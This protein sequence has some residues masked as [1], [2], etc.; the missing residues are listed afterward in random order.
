MEKTT[1]TSVPGVYESF[2]DSDGNQVIVLDGLSADNPITSL[3]IQTFIANN[4]EFFT[5][6]Y[7]LLFVSVL[8]YIIVTY[9]TVP[10]GRRYNW[11]N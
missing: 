10:L 11:F 8:I 2:L 6:L 7:W 5:V 3:P 9:I 4:L 1:L